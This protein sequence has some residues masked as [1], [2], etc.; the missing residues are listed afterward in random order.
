MKLYDEFLMDLEFYGMPKIIVNPK[1]DQIKAEFDVEKINALSFKEALVKYLEYLKMFEEYFKRQ[2]LDRYEF[3]NYFG[4]YVAKCESLMT[5]AKNN[6]RELMFDTIL[7]KELETFNNL[8][9]TFNMAKS[10]KQEYVKHMQKYYKDT[11]KQLKQ[12]SKNA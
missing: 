10:E 7:N 9:L 3:V 12:E 2:K 8:K 11:K 1:L 5:L 6:N 4:D